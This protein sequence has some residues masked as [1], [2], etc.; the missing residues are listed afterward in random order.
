MH[1]GI[2]THKIVLARALICS[3]IRI[4]SILKWSPAF[5]T[6]GCAASMAP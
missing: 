2:S 3:C 1:T 4:T 5:Y 6:S